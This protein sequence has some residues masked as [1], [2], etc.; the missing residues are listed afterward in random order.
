MLQTE[1]RMSVRATAMR[2]GLPTRVISRAVWLGELTA[3]RTTT[4]TG[5]ERIYIRF[6]DA[7]SWFKSLSSES[8]TASVGGAE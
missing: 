7:D 1:K 8:K 4:E 3:I 5:R 2:L 6:V